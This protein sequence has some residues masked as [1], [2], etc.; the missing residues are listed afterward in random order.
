[1]T[2]DPMDELRAAWG[3]VE[4]PPP[5]RD[6]SREDD[7]T[8]RAVAWMQG[9]WAGVEAPPARVPRRAARVR[10]G[11]WSLAA[12]A[13]V[14]AALVTALAQGG[15]DRRLDGGPSPTPE[16]PVVRTETEPP[17]LVARTAENEIELRSGPVCLVLLAGAPPQPDDEPVERE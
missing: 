3:E 7:A 8:R 5:D 16:T 2:R 4:A 9:A 11:P 12:A 17:V 1:M 10:V 6:L 13:A 14:V 15:R